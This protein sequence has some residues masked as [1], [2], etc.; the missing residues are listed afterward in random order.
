MWPSTQPIY[1]SWSRLSVRRMQSVDGGGLWGSFWQDVRMSHTIGHQVAV[2]SW[3]TTRNS[4]VILPNGTD[5]YVWL[6][7]PFYSHLVPPTPILLERMPIQSLL[8]ALMMPLWTGCFIA[9]LCAGQKERQSSG[10][11]VRKRTADVLESNL[12]FTPDVG[13]CRSH[14]L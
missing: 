12:A 6:Q 8:V 3:E 11:P 9:G 2:E 4:E 13:D 7:L 1:H 10:E 5:A 14:V